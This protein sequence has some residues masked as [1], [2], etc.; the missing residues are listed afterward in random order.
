MI[1]TRRRVIQLAGLSGVAPLLGRDVFADDRCCN[2]PCPPCPVGYMLVEMRGVCMKVGW[3]TYRPGRQYRVRAC[4]QP[5]ENGNYRLTAPPFLCG[6]GTLV[7]GRDPQNPCRGL[8]V[9]LHCVY[10]GGAIV[11][12]VFGNDPACCPTATATASRAMTGTGPGP[13]PEPMPDCTEVNYCQ[14]TCP[15]SGQSFC[16]PDIPGNTYPCPAPDGPTPCSRPPR[17]EQP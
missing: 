7:F 14:V 11:K 5:V 15:Y 1:L 17:P 4:Y 12:N 16:I 9:V 6:T 2:S 13:G 3:H 8:R 10:A